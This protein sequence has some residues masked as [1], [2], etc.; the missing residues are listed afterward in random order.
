MLARR[1][2]GRRVVVVEGLLCVRVLWL[3]GDIVR[4]RL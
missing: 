2:E 4:E 3:R 1:G